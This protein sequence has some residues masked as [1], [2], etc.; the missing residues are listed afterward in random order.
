MIA[1]RP[2]ILLYVARAARLWQAAL[3]GKRSMPIKARASTFYRKAQRTAGAIVDLQNL[4]HVAVG[5]VA[6]VLPCIFGDGFRMHRRKPC[7]QTLPAV[8]IPVHCHKAG[9]AM[10]D[11]RQERIGIAPPCLHDDL[12]GF[13]IDVRTVVLVNIIGRADAVDLPLG[14]DAIQCKSSTSCFGGCNKSSPSF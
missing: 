3:A 8:L 11:A 14:S 4:L 10:E 7:N 9:N 2:P 6:R 12:Q 13:L 1:I 5:G